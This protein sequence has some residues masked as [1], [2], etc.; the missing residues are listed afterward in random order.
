MPPQ[1]LSTTKTFSAS[2]KGHSCI[3]HVFFAGVFGFFLL[4]GLW[5]EKCT[6]L[7][8]QRLVWMF[9][10]DQTRVCIFFYPQP[11]WELRGWERCVWGM[12]FCIGF[13]WGLG[14]VVNLPVTYGSSSI[15]V[16]GRLSL[17]L[18]PLLLLLLPLL[19]FL[20]HGP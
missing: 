14:V 15:R 6:A 9:F 17:V 16:Y 12:C 13:C 3:I 4:Q 7:E 11:C 19:L 8:N 5:L 18:V 1:P 10:S 2:R 20:L